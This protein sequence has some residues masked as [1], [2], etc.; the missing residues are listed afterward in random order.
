MIRYFI[1]RD[2]SVIAEGYCQEQDIALVDTLGGQLVFET[3]LPKAG[4]DQTTLNRIKRQQLL[5]ASDWTQLPDVPVAT[6]EAWAI[7]R[8]ALRD[9]TEQ[10]DPFNINWPVRP[11]RKS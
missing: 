6:K 7:Y 4:V 2:G 9:I 11:D 1:E 10:T 3:S 5:E 8:Q